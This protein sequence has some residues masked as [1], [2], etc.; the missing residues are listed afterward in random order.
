MIQYYELDI[1]VYNH[2]RDYNNNL[3]DTAM[4]KMNVKSKSII[5][6]ATTSN[7]LKWA[8]L[9]YRRPPPPIPPLS[10]LAKK[11]WN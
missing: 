6:L 7:N 2:E 11:R 8:I 5:N 4:D 9:K 1:L 3:M 10:D